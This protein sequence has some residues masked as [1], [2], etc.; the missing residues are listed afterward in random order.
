MK[1]SILKGSILNEEKVLKFLEAHPDKVRT[2]LALEVCRVN[3]PELN[4][5]GLDCTKDCMGS[6]TN[7]YIL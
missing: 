6:I 4:C 5:I 7:I 1:G 3:S 2:F